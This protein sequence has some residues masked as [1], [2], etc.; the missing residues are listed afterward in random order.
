MLPLLTRV[1]A[2]DEARIARLPGIA[3]AEAVAIRE[4][5]LKERSLAEQQHVSTA[6]ITARDMAA[7]QHDDADDADDEDA[8]ERT[9]FL[10]ARKAAND[11]LLEDAKTRALSI[12]PLAP[13]SAFDETLRDR[14]L[15]DARRLRA[16][17]EAVDDEDDEDA[18][19]LQEG[20]SQANRA[21]R[22]S[23]RLLERNWRA[24]PGKRIAVPVRVEP[25]VYFAT[26][27]T[28]LVSGGGW[29]SSQ[30]LY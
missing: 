3:L 19:D 24:P 22:Q 8:D 4:K 27:R 17:E 6:N 26:E 28:F 2:K 20:M 21:R 10:K 23:E 15:E 25:K 13:S 11:A 1:T 12:D 7:P 29:L 9:P 18:A 14:L 30:C 16:A 5:N